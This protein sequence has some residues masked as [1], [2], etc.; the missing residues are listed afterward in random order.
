MHTNIQPPVPGHPIRASWGAAVTE[1]LNGLGV[2]APS[3]VLVRDGAGGIGFQPLPQNRRV[4][5]SSS[6]APFALREVAEDEDAGIPYTG[7]EIYLPSGCV[8]VGATCAPLNTPA[9]RTSD[10]ARTEVPNWYRIRH[11]D[12][13]PDADTVWTVAVHA[14]S[15]SA[16]AGVDAQEDW[17][18]RYVFAEIHDAGRTQQEADADMSD[19]G[20]TFSQVVGT[21]TFTLDDDNN[22]IPHYSQSVRTP[23]AVRDDLATPPFSLV[24]SMDTDDDEVTPVVDK[25][26]VVNQSFSAA[27]ASFLTDLRT[28]VEDDQVEAL[29]LY[30]HTDTTPYTAEIKQYKTLTVSNQQLSVAAQAESDR[31]VG[32][33]NLLLYRL[34]NYK[35]V[36]DNRSALANIQLY[37]Q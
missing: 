19:A 27:G 7:W 24:H 35:V 34:K 28:E 32:D 30:V 36:Q 5:S 17:P 4:M 26:V 11:P 25:V 12:G 16:H 23:I 33:L 22:P 10:G 2:M 31:K 9:Y 18:K 29:Y 13:A 37:Q 6:L 20:D 15:Y 21:V 1:A 3:G 14:K 8:A